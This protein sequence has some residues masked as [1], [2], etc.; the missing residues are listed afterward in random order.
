MPGRA[1]LLTRD[2]DVLHRTVRCLLGREDRSVHDDIAGADVDP[3]SCRGQDCDPV[4]LRCTS[5]QGL[6]VVGPVDRRAVVRVMR[7]GQDHRPDLGRDESLK[8]RGHALDGATRLDVAVEEVAGDQ[9]QV[10]LLGDRQIDRG[11]ERGELAFS[12]GTRLLAE[13]VMT[14]AEVDVRGM[15]DA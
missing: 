3:A 8:L 13:V 11:D 12:L 5:G 6:E 14:G 1:T 7:P 4:V 2:V 15:D 10:D 9:D